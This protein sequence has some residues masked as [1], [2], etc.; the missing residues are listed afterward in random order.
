MISYDQQLKALKEHLNAMAPSESDTLRVK[1]LLGRNPD[2]LYRTIKKKDRIITVLSD[3]FVRNRP[4]PTMFWLVDKELIKKISAIESTG[5][6]KEMEKESEI[7]EIVEIDNKNYS[8]LRT[9]FHEC[10]HEKMD[11]SSS[12]YPTI[13]ESGAGGIQDHKRVRC[14]HLHMGYHYSVGSNLGAYLIKKYPEL[15]I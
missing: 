5:I 6:I 14:L 9:Y 8:K 2:G 13:Y 12:Y 15:N 11:E 10:L 7:Q 4:F 3:T 1:Q